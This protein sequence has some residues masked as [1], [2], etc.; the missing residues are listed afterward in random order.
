MKPPSERRFPCLPFTKSEARVSLGAHFLRAK[1]PAPYQPRATPWVTRHT[2]LSP[3]GATQP[4]RRR[5]MT[6]PFRA[7]WERN[8]KPRAMPWAGMGRTVGAEETERDLLFHDTVAPH[9]AA[10]P[11]E[12]SATQQREFLTQ[13][14]QTLNAPSHPIRNRLLRITSDSPDLLAVINRESRV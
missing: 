2:H 3:E 5:P 1:G 6:R 12:A 7:Q 4:V 11:P 14:H 8:P 9:R 13:F 10:Y